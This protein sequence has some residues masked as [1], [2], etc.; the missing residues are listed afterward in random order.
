[1]RVIILLFFSFINASDTCQMKAMLQPEEIYFLVKY[2]EKKNKIPYIKIHHQIYY[3]FSG[4][5]GS[6]WDFH[7]TFFMDDIPL[8][9]LYPSWL[10]TSDY[11]Y[12]YQIE[13]DFMVLYDILPYR[14]DTKEFP[15]R[16]DPLKPY[17]HYLI[18]GARIRPDETNIVVRNIPCNLK[19]YMLEMEFD[20]SITYVNSIP[21]LKVLITAYFNRVPKNR[22][23]PNPSRVNTLQHQIKNV[24]LYI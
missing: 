22:R 7:E 21:T 2:D 1:M 23:Q 17:Y 12:P 24:F 15:S 10:K 11:S 8:Q 9:N 13:V 5:F 6:Y 20:H 16:I 18:T 4:K 3:E 19:R 14:R